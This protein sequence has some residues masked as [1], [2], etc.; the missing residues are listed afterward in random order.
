MIKSI[1]VGLDG[2][3]ASETGLIQAVSWARLL[4][5]ELRGV[6]I[7][8]EQRFVSYPTGISAEGGV[9]IS[10]PLP[11][12]ELAEENDKVRAEGKALQSAYEKAAQGLSGASF[13]QI[14]GNINDLMTQE[15]RLAD[16]V[17]MGRRGKNEQRNSRKPGPTTETLIHNALRPVMVV[18][19]N[20]VEGGVL[21][22]FDGSVGG[23]RV[24][25]SGVELAAAKGG[26]LDVISIGEDQ[27][28]AARMQSGLLKYLSPYKLDMEFSHQKKQ[29]RISDMIVSEARHRRSGLIVM[30]AFGHNPIR[31][32]IFG[33]TTLEVLEETICPVLLMV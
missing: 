29:G 13:T 20:P 15:A 17:V 3:P 5:A 31:E 27:D 26:R 14:R 4:K 21:L 32:L 11:E 30:G 12:N 7:E 28:E 25:P 19:E 24:L 18:P 9:P 23:Q 6:F 33:S 10:V 22:A 1:L 16:M 8:D 2:S